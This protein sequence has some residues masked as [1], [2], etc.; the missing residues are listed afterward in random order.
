MDNKKNQL[1]AYQEILIS[2][3]L[4]VEKNYTYAQLKAK[5]ISE[6]EM[7]IYAHSMSTYISDEELAAFEQKSSKVH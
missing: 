4:A 2:R 5:D 7:L 1:Y 6:I 3:V